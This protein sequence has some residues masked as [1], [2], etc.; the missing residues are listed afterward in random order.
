MTPP[1]RRAWCYRPDFLAW[2]P[3]R[4]EQLPL[5]ARVIITLRAQMEH[6]LEHATAQATRDVKSLELLCERGTRAKGGG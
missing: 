2:A 5:R 6:V 1:Q 3:T 4:L